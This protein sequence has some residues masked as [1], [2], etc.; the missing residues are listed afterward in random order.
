MSLASKRK[1]QTD[2]TDI[3]REICGD[4]HRTSRNL[5]KVIQGIEAKLEA[6]GEVDSLPLLDNEEKKSLKTFLASGKKIIDTC[7]PKKE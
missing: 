3:V 5:E 6:A 1:R 4:V 2:N 7:L